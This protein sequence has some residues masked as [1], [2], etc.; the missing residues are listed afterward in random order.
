[1]GTILYYVSVYSNTNAIRTASRSVSLPASSTEIK[2][3]SD[4]MKK[5]QEDYETLKSAVSQYS[6]TLQM[7]LM[8]IDL[9]VD[10][11]VQKDKNQSELFKQG[12]GIFDTCL[13]P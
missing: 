8:A 10:S 13:T 5:L 9:L 6:T 2:G 1:M 11:Q 12:T 7:D 3:Q 4:A